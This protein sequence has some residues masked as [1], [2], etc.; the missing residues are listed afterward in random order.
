MNLI[1]IFIERPIFL[2]MIEIFLIVLGI[3]GY[4]KIGVDLYPEIE[5]FKTSRLRVSDVHELYV[6][7]VGNPQGQAGSPP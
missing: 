4:Q 7:E 1:R 5:P 2:L 6:E 3:I